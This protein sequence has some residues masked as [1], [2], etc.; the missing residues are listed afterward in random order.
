MNNSPFSTIVSIGLWA[1]L[2][3]FAGYGLGS[4]LIDIGMGKYG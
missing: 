3:A 2:C 4:M 1:I